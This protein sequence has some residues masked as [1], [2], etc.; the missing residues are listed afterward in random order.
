MARSGGISQELRVDGQKEVVAAFNEIG[1]AGEQNFAKIDRGSKT[2]AQSLK[3]F[4][5]ETVG[6]R[7]ASNQLFRQF[8]SLG[9]SLE[10]IGA[11]LG[12]FGGGILGGVV[13]FAAGRAIGS[14]V[15]QLGQ[16]DERLRK[17]RDTAR[18]MGQKPLVVQA[19]QNI[20]QQAGEGADAGAKILG[21]ISDLIQKE[22]TQTK[23]QTTFDGVKE[24]R[25]STAAAG[26]AA[27]TAA[28]HFQVFNGVIDQ[29]VK[30]FKGGV[31]VMTDF[32]DPLKT[33]GVD[34]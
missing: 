28:G 14:V 12:S 27:Q 24:L 11:L 29:T 13:G 15:E 22:A 32:S 19:F 21:G 3:G 1:A 25:G 9:S 6:M 10:N 20:A 26:E 7:K 30:T 33:I 34:L 4:T 2:A 16:V 17:I 18:E 23:R 8:G 31:P 5:R